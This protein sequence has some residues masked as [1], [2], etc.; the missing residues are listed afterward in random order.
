MLSL[1][2]FIAYESTCTVSN[3]GLR[4]Q[5]TSAIRQSINVEL[6]TGTGCV[7]YDYY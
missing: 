2:Y 1:T 7:T 4:G 5:L 3:L 6:N